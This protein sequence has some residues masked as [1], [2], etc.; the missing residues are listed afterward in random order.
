MQIQTSLTKALPINVLRYIRLH[1]VLLMILLVVLDQWSKQCIRSLLEADMSF[2]YI[3]NSFLSFVGSWNTGVSFGA[4][5]SFE[6]SNL[7]IAILGSFVVVGIFLYTNLSLGWQF[8]A[9]GA[10]GNI[11]DRIVHGAVYDFFYF[12]YESYGFAIFNLADVYINIGFLLL[13]LK[14]NAAARA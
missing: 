10:I 1:H 7:A 6:Y 8:V 12:H 9:A 13:L 11:I 4:L 2:E 14:Y 5:S 3:V